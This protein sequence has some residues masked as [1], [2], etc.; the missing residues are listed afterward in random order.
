M[1]RKAILFDEKLVQF[2]CFNGTILYR[3]FFG[4][5]RLVW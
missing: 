1:R 5:G 4:I 2:F 3:V